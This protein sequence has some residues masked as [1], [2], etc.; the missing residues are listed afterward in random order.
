MTKHIV[1]HY[2][3]RNPRTAHNKWHAL[4]VITSRLLTTNLTTTPQTRYLRFTTH[5]LQRWI[6]RKMFKFRAFELLFHRMTS[7]IR[8]GRHCRNSSSNTERAFSPSMNNW[9]RP[10]SVGIGK[11]FR[12]TNYWTNHLNAP[13]WNPCPLIKPWGKF[14][15]TSLQSSLDVALAASGWADSTRSLQTGL[16][17]NGDKFFFVPDTSQKFSQSGHQWHCG[18]LFMLRIRSALWIWNYPSSLTGTLASFWR[19]CEKEFGL[20]KSFDERQKETEKSN[21]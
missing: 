14:S 11:S 4:T 2:F 15:Q 6:S 20:R 16:G 1:V 21:F 3:A 12:P 5:P 17:L 19:V 7:I 9:C 8:V 13:P 18:K 10:L